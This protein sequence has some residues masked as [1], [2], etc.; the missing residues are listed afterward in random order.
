MFI[1]AP[2]ARITAS[3]LYGLQ[4]VTLLNCCGESSYFE[5]SFQLV[6]TVGS[7]VSLLYPNNK[8]LYRFHIRWVGWPINH[9]AIILLAAKPVT[10]NLDTVGR[11]QVVLEKEI[12]ISIKILSRW[13]HKVLEDF[14]VYN[15]MGFRFH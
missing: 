10:S 3:F 12:S 1:D 9:N 11:C 5:S 7:G 4:A 15:C 6:C 2:S 14:Q 13:E 8:I